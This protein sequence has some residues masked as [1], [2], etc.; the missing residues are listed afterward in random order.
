[1]GIPKKRDDVI[2]LGNKKK[3]KKQG[4]WESIR[5]VRRSGQKS[6]GKKK[7]KK[8]NC[9]CTK[10]LGNTQESEMK[11]EWGFKGGWGATRDP[12]KGVFRGK[13]KS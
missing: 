11:R 13:M 3:R 10:T 5:S 9:H 7:D 1:M 6:R 2:S 8:N 4:G 12:G